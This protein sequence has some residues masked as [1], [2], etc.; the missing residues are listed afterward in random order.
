MPN[1][2]TGI[3]MK[4]GTLLCLDVS[5]VVDLDFCWASMLQDRQRGI[6]EKPDSYKVICKC[7]FSWKEM[8]R[9]EEKDNFDLSFQAV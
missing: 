1:A 3:I 2:S 9:R 5:N 8:H 7:L 6:I 4:I